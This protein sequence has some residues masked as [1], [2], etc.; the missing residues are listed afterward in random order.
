M[1]TPRTACTTLV[2]AAHKVDKAAL[3]SLFIHAARFNARNARGDTALN[4]AIREN[5]PG[6]VSLLLDADLDLDLDQRERV[7]RTPIEL[8]FELGRVGIAR[9]LLE[10][11]ANVAG[12]QAL[13][14]TFC[15]AAW[16]RLDFI[17]HLLA[18]GVDVE[19]A[20]PDGET[21]LIAAAANNHLKLIALLVRFGANA[22]ATTNDGVNAAMAAAA[23]GHLPALQ[24]FVGDHRLHLDATT[25]NGMTALLKAAKRGHVRVVRYLVARGADI[26]AV[27]RDGQDI[28]ILAAAN[29]HLAVLRYVIEKLAI[30]ANGTTDRS[31]LTALHL[32]A[33]RGHLRV[34]DYLVT[35][36]VIGDAT[37]DAG[38]S[39]AT[40]A[41]RNGQL[42]V[43]EFL[44]IRQPKTDASLAT[45]TPAAFVALVQ[46]S[47]GPHHSPAISINGLAQLTQEQRLFDAMLAEIEARR[48]VT[49][50]RF[51][52]WLARVRE[53]LWFTQGGLTRF[54][55][56]LEVLAVCLQALPALDSGAGRG[57]RL[58]DTACVLLA[59]AQLVRFYSALRGRL[60]QPGIGWT[61]ASEFQSHLEDHMKHVATTRTFLSILR[62]GNVGDRMLL[63]NVL[64]VETRGER[65]K[66]H[67][68]S[69]HKTLIAEYRQARLAA[70]GAEGIR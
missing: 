45:M 35:K 25:T 31:G 50:G 18:N 13:P 54:L 49:A 59:N 52:A 26:H 65:A 4:F 69:G 56:A 42:E 29:G 27:T 67:R 16:G 64:K 58:N 39:V 23:N 53:G 32:A 36:C 40:I 19:A 24:Y 68:A 66:L 46:S 22:H 55:K 21:L 10:W 44:K 63:Q 11:K 33:A 34:V 70:T 17:E 2:H 62:A 61:T 20:D 38:E 12:M 47:A 5:R 30:P 43:L 15:C 60:N 28:I 3:K 8:A 57:K 1:Q 37:T 6:L 41:A 51:N 14:L 48:P 7:G 9:Q